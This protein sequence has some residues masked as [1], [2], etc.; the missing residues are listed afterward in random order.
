MGFKDYLNE[1]VSWA[2]YKG[3]YVLGAEYEGKAYVAK[4]D[5]DFTVAYV[6]GAWRIQ[7][8]NGEEYEQGFK[9]AALAK[10][11]AADY[12]EGLMESEDLSEASA[13]EN[14]EKAQDAL[15]SAAQAAFESDDA[16]DSAVFKAMDKEFARIE[17]LFGYSPGSWTRGV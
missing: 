8:P 1:K 15:M 11:A 12:I 2:T 3:P 16:E 13:K 9:T 4:G 5:L 14:K 10:K 17:K 7:D 6:D